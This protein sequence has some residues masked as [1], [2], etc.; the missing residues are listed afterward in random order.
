VF[1]LSPQSSKQRRKKYMS[2]ILPGIRQ[3]NA[4]IF[5]RF[6]KF[7]FLAWGGP[8]AQIAMI[9][10][11]L[12]EEE[13]WI[14]TEKFNRALAVYQALP[15]PEAHELCVYFGMLAG[16]RWGGFLAGFAFML[17]GFVL[18]LLLTGFYLAFGIRSALVLAAFAGIQAVVVALIL[19]AVHRI[20]KHIL[21]DARLWTI[22]LVSA[23]A[24]ALGAHFLFI[25]LAAGLSY[26]FWM[27]D[28]VAI[29]L[30]LG[31]ALLSYAAYTFSP[32]IFQTAATSGA[33]TAPGFLQGSPFQI[34]LSGLKG[35]L[36]TFGG[37]YTAIPFM[38]QEAV[39]EQAWMTQQQFL[40]GIALSGILPAPL[41]IFTT[42]IGYFGG[43]WPGAVLIT[44]GIFLPA[45][46]F[47]LIGHSLMERL[48]ANTA[49]HRFLDG[50]GAGAV[51]LIAATA[52]AL[53]KTVANDWFS[54]LICATAVFVL[55]RFKTKFMA[56]YIILGSGL[57]ALLR[58]G[59]FQ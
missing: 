40:D 26:F 56:I 29:P 7:G 17:P 48:I 45:F 4:Q 57:L 50:I 13:N 30:A 22:A 25:L 31:V 21:I 42:F 47:T 43:G 1:V 24:F 38:Q 39:I 19:T 23:L 33:T 14:T 12:V 44:V 2:D 53:L 27:R 10:R 35:G 58:H 46:S 15:G 52:I 8:T 11:E 54:I 32:E 18:M 28:K 20:G 49:L 34:F 36:L 16:G 5:M 59:L 37:A 3:T 9:K 41:I 6:L 55:Y 51:G